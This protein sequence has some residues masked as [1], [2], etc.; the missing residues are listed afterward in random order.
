M[1]GVVLAGGQQHQKTKPPPHAFVCVYYLSECLGK[2]GFFRE[3][4]ES[5][6]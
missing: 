2:I 3:F 4:R 5:L 1:M 6:I